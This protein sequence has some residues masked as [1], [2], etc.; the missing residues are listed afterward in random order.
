MNATFAA[1]SYI[2]MLWRDVYL[3]ELVAVVAG[4]IVENQLASGK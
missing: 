3:L 1:E 2:S 4:L